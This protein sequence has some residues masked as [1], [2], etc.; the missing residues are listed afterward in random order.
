[1]K[2]KLS[3]AFVAAGIIVALS[4]FVILSML[5][6]TPADHLRR[7]GELAKEDNFRF[8]VAH[9]FFRSLGIGAYVGWT[10]ILAWAVVVFFREAAG[11]LLLRGVSLGVAVLTGA[12]LADILGSDNLGGELGFA[13][14]SVLKGSLGAT[15]GGILLSGLFLASL[16]F[17]TEFGFQEHLRSAA[18]FLTEP[19]EEKG[20]SDLV[21]GFNE[22]AEELLLRDEPE[23]RHVSE[24]G[25]VEPA[26]PEVEREETV[27]EETYDTA[28]DAGEATIRAS[29]PLHIETEHLDDELLI[30]HG[31]ASSGERILVRAAETRP[32]AVDFA[33][34]DEP[35]DEEM[36]GARFVAPAPVAAPAPETIEDSAVTVLVDT[37]FELPEQEL[38]SL[39]EEVT[40]EDPAARWKPALESVFEALVGPASPPIPPPSSPVAEATR[41]DDPVFILDD[42]LTIVGDDDE[43]EFPAPIPES[44][45]VVETPAWIET[46]APVEPLAPEE[47][48]VAP[49]AVAGEIAPEIVEE[50][51]APPGPA[52]PVPEEFVEFTDS[53]LPFMREAV[54]PP[55]APVPV[56]EVAA[57][58]EAAPAAAEIPVLEDLAVV[59]PAPKPLFRR[60][61]PEPAPAPESADPL[62]EEAA[63]IFLERGRASVVLLQRRLDIG[64]TRASR[65]VESLAGKGLVGP[66]TESGSREVLLSREDWELRRAG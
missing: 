32:T 24:P 57:A 28:G 15:V 59:R 53:F 54:E 45:A 61:K 47:P 26:A 9:L 29:D 41:I 43:P 62:L 3:P 52:V 40:T 36:P 31:P 48:P 50:S 6:Y 22:G 13:V 5:F 66:L 46:P 20:P 51:V 25:T 21:S 7:A 39:E 35:D 4:L 18:R 64:Y 44:P 55:P 10:V 12:A 63:S 19:R 33:A 56:V 16:A 65:I 30:G 8:H 49:E 58:P 34:V 1:M 42:E 14:A 38:E 37:D 23:T 2:K 60:R 11:E 17:A 27:A